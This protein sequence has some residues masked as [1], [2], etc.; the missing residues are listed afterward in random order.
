MPNRYHEFE[1]PTKGGLNGD[2]MGMHN[3]TGSLQ[4]K[5]CA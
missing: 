1:E 5:V 4:D 2:K 3:G